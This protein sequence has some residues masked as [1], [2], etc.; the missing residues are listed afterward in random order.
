MTRTVVG[1]LLLGVLGA[2]IFWHLWPVMTGVDLPATLRPLLENQPRLIVAWINLLFLGTAIISLLPAALAWVLSSG[3]RRVASAMLA[4]LP[5]I[6][7]LL[8]DHAYASLAFDF[9]FRSALL[10]WDSSKVV[11]AAVGLF[12]MFDVLRRLTT[13]WSRP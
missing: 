2:V 9:H 12:I 3:E 4:S 8:G 1:L 11:V 5:L 7:L 10:L 6:G 13:R